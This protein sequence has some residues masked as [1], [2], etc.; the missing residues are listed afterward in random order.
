M[1][2]RLRM[3][4]RMKIVYV[5]DILF[6][7]FSLLHWIT[8]MPYGAGYV[9]AKKYGAGKIVDP[10][11][12]A[13]GS[14]VGVFQKFTHLQD[15]LPAMGY[16]EE[17]MKDLKATIENTPFDTLV[18]GTPSNFAEIMNLSVPAVVARYELEMA[19]P[20]HE[21]QFHEILDK[22]Y[23]EATLKKKGD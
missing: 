2:L 13:Q 20:E 3:V 14:L 8:G 21:K 9:L 18:I 16:G 1:D 12:H 11:P 5:D 15:V 17:Q 23:E 7:R 22:F 4:V 19:I 6:T 10:R